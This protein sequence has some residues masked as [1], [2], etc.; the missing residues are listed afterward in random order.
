MSSR[1]DT[2]GNE[3]NIKKAPATTKAAEKLTSRAKTKRKSH[4]KKRLT[5]IFVDAGVQPFLDDAVSHIQVDTDVSSMSLC[6]QMGKCGIPR[7]SP[8]K[9]LSERKNYDTFTVRRDL[10]IAE[11]AFAALESH[12]HEGSGQEYERQN[13]LESIPDT[14][15][16]AR[17]FITEL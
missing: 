6:A 2:L 14:A 9:R 7:D 17:V 16:E 15:D 12:S 11:L 1:N 13:L 10:L 4:F 8:D 3:T 5:T